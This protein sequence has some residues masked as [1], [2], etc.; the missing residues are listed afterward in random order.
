MKELE[1]LSRIF[2]RGYLR[3]AK[4]SAQ[5]EPKTTDKALAEREE[6]VLS[7]TSRVNEFLSLEGKR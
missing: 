4:L 5:I 1:E 6:T 2:A 3:L 7:V